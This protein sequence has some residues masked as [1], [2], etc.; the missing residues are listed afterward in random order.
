MSSS[1]VH[2]HSMIPARLR[3][4]A[5]VDAIR[6]TI[7]AHQEMVEEDISLEEVREVLLAAQVVED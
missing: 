2:R 4:Q 7:H 1:D 6:I 5:A 3:R